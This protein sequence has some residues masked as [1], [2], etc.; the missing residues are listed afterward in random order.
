[1]VDNYIGPYKIFRELAA[2]RV[3][4][5]FEATDPARKKSVLIKCLR[6]DFANR[7]EVVSRLY[8]KA[9]TLALLNHEHI[10]RIN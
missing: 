8:S 3:G 7:P 1:M 9:E 5:V 10:A 6:N 2:D 4:R